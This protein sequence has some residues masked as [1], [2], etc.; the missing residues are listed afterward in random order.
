[1]CDLLLG[2]PVGK[3]HDVLCHRA[4]GTNL[5]L[6][7]PIFTN[8]PYTCLDALF[9]HVKTTTTRV[10][11]PMLGSFFGVT[12]NAGGHR[13]RVSLSRVL[14]RMG[15]QQFRVRSDVRAILL[16][17]LMASQIVGLLSII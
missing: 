13:D 5:M 3:S 17:E 2:K 1:V 4:E 6:D 14:I 16:R 10:D 8:A 7:F 15:R 11:R 9:M 12:L